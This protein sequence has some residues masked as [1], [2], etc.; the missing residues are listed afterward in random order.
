MKTSSEV[1]IEEEKNENQE[2]HFCD[3][4]FFSGKKE[5]GS[6]DYSNKN[7]LS[8]VYLSQIKFISSSNYKSCKILEF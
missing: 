7:D 8:N 2:R 6:E 5:M 3:F 4:I 1:S